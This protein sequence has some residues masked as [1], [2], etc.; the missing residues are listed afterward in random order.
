[1]NIIY[2]HGGLGNQLFQYAL[3]SQFVFKGIKSAV[4]EDDVYSYHQ[5]TAK[6]HIDDYLNVK[7]KRLN[8]IHN[9][10]SYSLRN[11]KVASTLYD[12]F[13]FRCYNQYEET[14]P[15]MPKDIMN[16]KNS[17]ID[18][19]FQSEYFFPDKEVQDNLRKQIT[20]KDNIH[21]S[22]QFKK[23]KE[24]IV[25]SNSVFLHIRRSD[26]LLES[27]KPLY[28][29]ICTEKYY[30]NAI[31]YIDERVDKPIFYVFSDDKK[32]IEN[33]YGDKENFI[34]V[35][36]YNTLN[37]IEEFFLMSSCKHSICTNSSFS[38]WA[39]WLNNN[40]K[41]IILAP[42]KWNNKYN[43]EKTEYS[44]HSRMIKMPII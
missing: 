5:T 36:K 1:M 37:D 17:C 13:I 26:Y 2:F 18:G 22:E 39:S 24:E 10:I 21:V 38:W 41:A 16:C 30:E 44:Y 19:F 42:E 33:K 3:Y 11:N 27:Y 7:Y 9:I 34:V 31:K 25:N 20:L 43:E 15:E 8:P 35:N 4:I 40:Q 32:Y 23:L 29:N 28:G 12:Y 6:I 14:L